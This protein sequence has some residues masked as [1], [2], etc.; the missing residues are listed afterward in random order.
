MEVEAV[1]KVAFVCL[2]CHRYVTA[3]GGYTHVT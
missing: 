3:L 2:S 1:A